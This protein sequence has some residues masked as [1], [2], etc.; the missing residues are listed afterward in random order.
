MKKYLTYGLIT[1]ISLNSAGAHANH[2]TS[3]RLYGTPG[4]LNNQVAVPGQKLRLQLSQTSVPADIWQDIEKLTT[5]WKLVGFGIHSPQDHQHLLQLSGLDQQSIQQLTDSH[6]F[7]LLQAMSNPQLL[8]LARNGDYAGLLLELKALGL[9]T[10][11]EKSDLATRFQMLLERDAAIRANVQTILADAGPN[12]IYRLQQLIGKGDRNETTCVGIAACVAL[13]AVATYVVAA[14]NVAVAVNVAAWLSVAVEIAV[15]VNGE[16][17]P[18]PPEPDGALRTQQTQLP[19]I[20][21][22]DRATADNFAII[23]QFSVLTASPE[24][25]RQAMLDYKKREARAVLTAAEN[26]GMLTIHDA[27]RADALR[28]LDLVVEEYY[29]VP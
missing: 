11:Y 4:S 28:Q 1:S 19:T 8:D 6:E 10:P 15:A 16:P 18:E 20:S 2:E 3:N 26:L 21:Q 5:A 14:V 9:M 22:L 17:V 29:G 24:L 12:H 7:R 25:R 13:I 23:E 27:E